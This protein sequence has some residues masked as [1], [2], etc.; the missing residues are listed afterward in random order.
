LALLSELALNGACVGD[1]EITN[2]SSDDS[3]PHDAQEW[4]QTSPELT[5]IHE[6]LLTAMQTLEDPTRSAQ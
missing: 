3:A 2:W 5:N 6:T 1:E 4:E